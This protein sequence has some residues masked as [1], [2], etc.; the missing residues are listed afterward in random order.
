MRAAL[1]RETSNCG[2]PLNV[3]DLWF[4]TLTQND[5]S[6]QAVLSVEELRR[7]SAF[8]FDRDAANF[9]ARRGILLLILAAYTG[10][11][12]S[13]LSF[14]R[15]QFGKPALDGC[16]CDIRFSL[17]KS[18]DL[19]VYA[20]ARRRDLGVDLELLGQKTL[21]IQNIAGSFP[22]DKSVRST[23]PP[24]IRKKRCSCV[25]GLS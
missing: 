18:S 1:N 6:L 19:S 16:F 8:R 3:V 10:V 5:F 22:K 11:P 20:F 25:C 9:V 24:L 13:E 14:T 17:S 12:P 23:I 2:L 21:E 4:A 15:N 7:A